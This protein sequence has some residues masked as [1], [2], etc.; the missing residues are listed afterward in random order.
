MLLV[1][2]P[3]SYPSTVYASLPLLCGQLVNNGINAECLDLNTAFFREIFS[4]GYL[5]NA[6]KDLE[7]I[8][9]EYEKDDEYKLILKKFLFLEKDKTNEI[10]EKSDKLYNILISKN[11]SKKD[12]ELLIHAISFC[13]IKS[14]PEKVLFTPKYKSFFIRNR[15]Y[16]LNY[17]SLLKKCSN[18]KNNIYIDIFKKKVQEIN[19]KNYDI[20][21]ISIPF[22]TNLY[23]ALTFSKILKEET[24]AKVVIGGNLI[25]PTIN[26]YVQYPDI[27]EK[28]TDGFL[29]GE[30]EKALIDYV[31]YL[32][33]NI[34]IEEVSGLVYK[35]DSIVKKNSFARVNNVEQIKPPAFIG[36]NFENYS[37]PVVH[38]EFS[39]GCY[40]GKCAYCYTN[41]QKRYY[42]IQHK[43]AVD[44]VESIVKNHNLRQ[45]SILDDSFNP[46]FAEKFAEEILRRNLDISYDVFFRFEKSLTAKFLKKMHKSGLKNIFF[47][48]ESGSPRILQ[49]MNK[50]IDLNVAKK[51]LRNTYAIGINSYVGFIFGF[52][53][54]TITDVER[55]IAFQQ[56]NYK[57]IKKI[58]NFYF[59]LLKSSGL[60]FDK[61]KY[62]ISNIRDVEEFA[63]YLLYDAPSV[64]KEELQNLFK[65]YNMS[66]FIPHYTKF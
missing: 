22:E 63:D 19:K 15:D 41:E 50:G 58:N 62:E 65:K 4:S 39:K 60:L 5:V 38:L 37:N 21:A 48:L 57:Y 43:K 2:P 35:K 13:F 27:F 66:G 6:K 49:L 12:L 29:I 44:I 32:Q 46:N 51:I 45:F 55:T 7:Q 56:K 31:N 53:T 25:N 20:V 24:T 61:D 26:S 34:S 64:T 8:Y 18:L 42:I 40:W 59:T 17:D 36:I 30:G 16:S 14:Y 33:K 10:I 52:P 47:G 23:P 28:F 11:N 54:E 9:E 1:Y 3:L